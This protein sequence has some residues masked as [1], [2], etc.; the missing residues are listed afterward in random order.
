[1]LAA[2]AAVTALTVRAFAAPVQAK[3]PVKPGPVTNLA[4]TLTKA[5]VVVPT[6]KG[7]WVVRLTG[8]RK[9]TLFIRPS[10]IDAAGNVSKPVT[11]KAVLTVS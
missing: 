4:V 9:G 10:A 7:G 6:A 2:A 5:A 11:Q 1:M 8:L 3:P